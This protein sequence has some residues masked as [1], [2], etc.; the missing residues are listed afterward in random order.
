M[1]RARNVGPTVTRTVVVDRAAPVM[2]GIGVPPTL[3]GGQAA[4]FPASATD[5]LDLVGTTYLLAYPVTPTGSAAPLSIRAAGNDIGVAFDNTLTTSASFNLTIPSFV[6]TI[7]PT[8]GGI[9]PNSTGTLASSISVSVVDAAGNTSGA[10][11]QAIP[12][13]NI[14]QTALTNFFTPVNGL[15]FSG[16]GF[17]VSNVATNI[18]NCPAAGCAGG[19]APA[20]PTS[21]V[22]T[23]TIQ[24]Q[25]SP[26][27]QFANPFVSISFY[28][29]SAANEWQLIGTVTSPSGAIDNVAQTQ[30]TYSFTLGTAFDPPASLVPPGTLKIIAIGV[31]AKGD[32]LVTDVNTAIS[33]TNP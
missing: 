24:G 7:A 11:T 16:T 5:N 8:T 31:N 19:A 30:R 9:P 17:S 15:S 29:L 2:L 1:D 3:N 32:A 10:N 12:A 18:S 25:D 21:V 26:T 6:R 28:Y 33:I 4:S 20:N 23:A 14:N 22:L 27:F 13:L